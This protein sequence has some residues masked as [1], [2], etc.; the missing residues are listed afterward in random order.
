MNYEVISENGTLAEYQKSV[1]Q[2]GD[3]PLD[4]LMVDLFERAGLKNDDKIVVVGYFNREVQDLPQVAGWMLVVNEDADGY[5][6]MQNSK[7]KAI[8]R[9][10]FRHKF[11]AEGYLVDQKS[12]FTAT[13]DSP[14]WTLGS[15]FLTEVEWDMKTAQ[16]EQAVK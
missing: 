11:F 1:F 7:L 3:E 8:L 10:A 4:K 6:L 14:V 5:G 15:S 2:E 13:T 16:F 9:F 12:L